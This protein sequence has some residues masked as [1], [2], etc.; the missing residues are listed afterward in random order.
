M[1][2]VLPLRIKW[3]QTK[4]NDGRQW[5]VQQDFVFRWWTT[6]ARIFVH[7]KTHISTLM[8]MAPPIIASQSLD[9]QNDR[10][11]DS[12]VQSFGGLGGGEN[13]SQIYKGWRCWS[14]VNINPTQP[15]QWTSNFHKEITSKLSVRKLASS[16]IPG[17]NMDSL[18]NP[19]YPG[20]S[21]QE[22]LIICGVCISKCVEW[23]MSAFLS[24][25]LNSKNP[26]NL[27]SF[28]LLWSMCIY[29]YIANWKFILQWPAS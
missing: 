7:Q 1:E 11:P 28:P 3:L 13:R 10:P 15:N 2:S 27:P 29:I 19:F 20:A 25:L 26:G 17:L 23:H 21:P 6:P 9:V 12:Q 4:N 5:T 22:S 16:L 18:K 24:P 14:F 8:E